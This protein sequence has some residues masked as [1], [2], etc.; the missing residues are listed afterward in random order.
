[1]RSQGKK[2]LHLILAL[3]AAMPIAVLAN[4]ASF[5]LW[6]GLNIHPAYA[7][8]TPSVDT[9]ET[10]GAFTNP[11]LL[12]RIIAHR[13]TVKSLTFSPDGRV[14]S[15]GSYNDGIIRMWNPIT[16]K[17]VATI[18]KAQTTT[19]ESVVV[20][21]DGLT[22]VSC[23]SDKAINLWNFKSNQFTR[24]FVGHSSSV[25]SL[26]ISPDSRVLVS[27]A[28][29]GI[30]TWDLLQQRPLATLVRFD[31]TIYTVAISSDG[32]TVASGDKKGVIKLWNINTG[33]LIRS[34]VAHP[35]I[36]T[37]V[38]FTPD[39][40]NL[41]SSSR[42]RTVKL[43]NLNSQKL[44]YTLK[45]HSNWVNAIAIHPN[46]QILA[47]AGRDGIKVWDLTT[48]QL[49]G[50]LIGHSDWVNAIAFSRDGQMLA[51]GGF[52][53]VVNIWGNPSLVVQKK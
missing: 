46:G 40:Q 5:N 48:G 6:P 31:N 27:G 14:I 28:L 21:P 11:R 38:A 1:M 47:S 22:L 39:G 16:G 51:S 20:S 53:G 35:N 8:P 37:N 36:V 42:D 52:D 26:A 10:I 50:S 15:G 44:V 12:R 18:T 3:I 34:F 45:G 9:P 41:V 33:K 17:K 4:A 23:G 24:S 2:G 29:D 19:V 25:L 43:W 13:G 49:L 32:Q 30:R 7:N